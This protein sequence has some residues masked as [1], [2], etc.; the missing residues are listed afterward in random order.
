MSLWESVTKLVKDPPPAHIFELSEAGVA[1]FSGVD[2]GFAPLPGGALEASPVENNVREAHLIMPV[3]GQVSAPKPGATGGRRRTAAVMLPDACARVSV[4]DFDAF[5]AA[6]AEQLSLVR[7]RVKKTIPFD[8]ESAA[9]SYYVQSSSEKKGKTDVVAVTIA[10][11]VLARYEA[12]F[13]NAGFH[14]G[15]VTVSGLAALNLYKGQEPAIVAKLAGKTLT[16]MVVGGGKLKLFRCVTLESSLE[17]GGERAEVEEIRSVLYPTFAYAE[18]E[19]GSPIRRAILCGFEEP[20]ENLPCESEPL[21]GRFG[22]AGPFNA[23]LLGYLEAA[24]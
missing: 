18:D 8:I 24:L 14:A 22:V 12:L 15:D 5:P 10:L 2:T 9:V 13:R 11:E 17:H 19:L 21:R 1:H 4:L 3:L 7:F 23:G 20:L 6:P 16:V